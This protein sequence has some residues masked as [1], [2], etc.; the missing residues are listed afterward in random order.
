[1]KYLVLIALLC[2]LSCKSADLNPTTTI[3]KHVLTNGGS[4]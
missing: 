2:L 3:L 4:K 1:M